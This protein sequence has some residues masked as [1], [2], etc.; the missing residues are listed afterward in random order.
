MR[1]GIVSREYPPETA[2]GGI[3]SQNYLK[4]HGLANRGHDVCV[5]SASPDHE[6][7]DYFDENVRVIRIPSFESR[8]PLY[9]EIAEWLTYSAEVAVAV[10]RL[11]AEMPMDLVE[12]PEWGGEGYVHLL[13]RTE[14]NHIPTAIH[15]HGPLVMLAETI[16]WPEMESEFYRLGTQMER[17]SVRLADAVLSSSACSADWCARRY[18]V[19]RDEITVIHMGVDTELFSPLPG[20][21][22]KRPT[23]VFVGNVV[24][25]KG[26]CNLIDASCRLASDF[27]DLHVK[28]IGRGDKI[29]IEELRQRALNAGRP[30]MIEFLGFVDRR[31]LPAYLARA[32]VLAVPSGY[33]GG[34]GLVYLEA[35][36]CG[37]PVIACEGSGAAEVVFPGQNGYLVPPGDTETL[38][39]SLRQLLTDENIREQIGRSA[40]QYVLEEANTDLCVERLEALYIEIARCGSR[41]VSESGR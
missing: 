21:K 20:L 9:T 38:V 39:V 8:I 19:K 2:H 14:W 7:H 30:G 24:A 25:N 16:G 12:F 29:Y 26:I 15:L 10:A 18:G 37:L 41:P 5:I 6:S 13:N 27:P 32:H 33:E 31:E 11:H 1:I 28:V 40:R 34:P 36:A 17:T 3:G 22:P 23:I 35:M 4:A